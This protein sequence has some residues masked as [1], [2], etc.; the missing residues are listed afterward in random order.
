MKPRDPVQIENL[1]NAI[2]PKYDLLNDVFSFGL[3]RIWKRQ[4]LIWLRPSLGEHWVDLCCG[5]GDLTLQLA[6]LVRPEGSV[7][8]IDFSP[9]QIDIASKRTS[10]E[11]WLPVSWLKGDAL[12]TGLPSGLF[13][14]V[15]MAYGLRNLE[16]PEAG[17]KEIRRLLRP[18]AK[19]GILDFNNA[20]K[21]S[22]PSFFQKYYLRNL[23]VP[24]ASSV[25]LSEEYSY[26]EESLKQ[27][28]KASVQEEM[29]IKLGFSE[30]DYRFLAGGQMG[31]LILKL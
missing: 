15:V 5:T 30:V 14:G 10:K 8:G 13:D 7:L 29:A 6:R 20:V 17:L 28:P 1:F 21:G 26:L 9:E 12:S 22:I 16:S 19:A 3:H 25:G 23:V 31:A 18:G 4:L 2:S 11:A 27:F 24:I